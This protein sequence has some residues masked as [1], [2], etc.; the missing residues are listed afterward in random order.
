MP[1]AGTKVI[2]YT[3][4]LLFSGAELAFIV[5]FLASVCCDNVTWKPVVFLQ[6]RLVT[7]RQTF[8]TGK[9][10]GQHSIKPTLILFIH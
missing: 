9:P 7:P 2:Y 10:F 6:Y 4:T 3:L 8:R 1:E 5:Y